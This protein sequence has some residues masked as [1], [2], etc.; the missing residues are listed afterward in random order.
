MSREHNPRREIGIEL[1]SEHAGRSTRNVTA[2]NNLVYDSTAIGIAIG[3]YDRRRG[4]TEDCV[5]VNNTFVNTDGVELLV[6]FD[7]RNNVIENNVIVAGARHV[8]VENDYRENAGNVLDHNL[9]FSLDGSSTG[10]WQWKGFGYDDF[11]RWSARSGNDRHSTFTDP[12][13]VDAAAHDFSIRAG[14]PAST[15]GR[16]WPPRARPTSQGSSGAGRGDRPGGVR[17]GGAPALPDP[18]DLGA[19]HVRG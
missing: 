1:A 10:T 4:S 5:I 8:F 11:D 2:R 14:S 3:G 19:D 18:Y 17:A 7:T 9:Y 16:S 13:F 6:Q 12:G 15:P